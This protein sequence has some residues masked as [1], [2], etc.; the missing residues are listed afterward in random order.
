MAVAQQRYTFRL[1]P[2]VGQTVQYTMKI[3]T[4][5]SLPDMNALKMDISTASQIKVLATDSQTNTLETTITG[6]SGS[7]EG[8]GKKMELDTIAKVQALVGKRTVVV[9]SPIGKILKVEQDELDFMGNVFEGLDQVNHI[10]PFSE[11][12]IAVGESWTGEMNNSRTGKLSVNYTLAE[13]TD[14]AYHITYRGDIN[15][16]SDAMPSDVTASGGIE[17]RLSIDRATGFTI[18]NSSTSTMKM[19]IEKSGQSI[20]MTITMAM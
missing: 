8:N 2:K 13:V 12:P 7:V 19:R 14:Q 20:G 15:L 10:T 5:M 18:P 4:E 11:Q 3:R 6:I 16:L 17:G 1:T 9:H